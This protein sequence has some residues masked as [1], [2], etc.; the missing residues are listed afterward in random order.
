MS[1]QFRNAIA[2]IPGS[3]FAEGLTTAS[4]GRPRHELALQQHVAYCEALRQCGLNL[5]MLPPDLAH[6][7]S[8][9]VEDAA[10]LTPKAAMVA[11]PG[12]PT[13]MGEAVVI[14]AE[15]AHF[16]PVVHAIEAPGTLDG[17]DIC[18]AGGHFFLGLSL[19]S[20]EEG[21]RQLAAFLAALGYTSTVIDVRATP[22]ILHLKSGLAYLGQNTV[23]LWESLADLPA[24]ARYERIVVA[25]EEQYAANCVRV[26]DRVLV[27][28]GFPKIIAELQAR[29]FHPLPLEMSEFEKM[30]GGLSCLSLRF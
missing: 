29:S 27:P 8:T 17:G 15:L 22:G 16:F 21:L 26:N 5:A 24:F 28:A 19:R 9:F 4:L 11:R 13:R 2:R 18:D 12:A 30:D 3:N 7:D 10:V 23:L 14:R 20:N 1:T 6:P 25:A